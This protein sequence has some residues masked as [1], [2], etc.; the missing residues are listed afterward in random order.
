V[1][2]VQAFEGD[3]AKLA[4]QLLLICG[5]ETRCDSVRTVGKTAIMVDLAAVPV[6]PADLLGHAFGP[7]T[8]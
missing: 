2:I 5:N 7:M 8:A 4:P 3:F 6:S 1:V